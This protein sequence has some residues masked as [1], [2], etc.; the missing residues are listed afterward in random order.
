MHGVC[1][2]RISP[3]PCM[4]VAISLSSPLTLFQFRARAHCV[5]AQP[6]ASSV[7]AEIRGGFRHLY[8]FTWLEE[9]AEEADDAPEVDVGEIWFEH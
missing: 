6:A 8:L 5:F 1:I 7:C 4:C 9:G 3:I 2:E